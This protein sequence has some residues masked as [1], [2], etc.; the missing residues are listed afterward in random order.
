M[1]DKKKEMLIE[2]NKCK[3]TLTVA[4]AAEAF[5]TTWYGLEK[6]AESFKEIIKKVDKKTW[7]KFA[8]TI[9]ISYLSSLYLNCDIDEEEQMKRIEDIGEAFSDNI[10]SIA[11][12]KKE[13]VSN[14]N[15][16]A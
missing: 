8:N 13:T 7:I 14:K 3:D 5:C 16:D 9:L 12:S 6:S 4:E 1:I 10:K 2:I 11:I 15:Y